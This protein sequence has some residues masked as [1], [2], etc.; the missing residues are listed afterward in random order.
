MAT[1]AA[2]APRAASKARAISRV[3]AARLR[4]ARVSDEMDFRPS[5]SHPVG[6]IKVTLNSYFAQKVLAKA[7][8]RA[9]VALYGISVLLRI[10]SPS[11]EVAIRAEEK[12]REQMQSLYA[13]LEAELDRLHQL[14]DTMAAPDGVVFDG[15][16]APR[17]YEVKF[18]NPLVHDYIALV[19]KLDEVMGVV[20]ML[21]MLGVL[22]DSQ[23][24]NV[25]NKWSGRIMHL[26][27]TFDQ[28]KNR[29]QAQIR[30]LRAQQEENRKAKLEAEAIHL[31][32][33]GAEASATHEPGEAAATSTADEH[34]AVAG[35]DDGTGDLAVE[36]PEGT[37]VELTADAKASG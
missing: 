16:S 25:A 15:Y 21:Y 23:R 22:D 35:D 4:V 36:A 7:Y 9:M 8:E 10:I 2:A 29:G 34:A 33:D 20:D 14:R 27:L 32:P 19:R 30:K 11:R 1:P 37:V 3:E 28:Q 26:A 5:Q 24:L 6:K 17:S 13:E 12:V 18:Y 31:D